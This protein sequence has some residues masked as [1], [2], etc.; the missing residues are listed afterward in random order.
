MSKSEG[1][2]T[3]TAEPNASV[4]TAVPVVPSKKK[5]TPKARKR[6]AS[7]A[8]AT[9]KTGASPAKKSASG[10]SGQSSDAAAGRAD[11]SGSSSGAIASG[12][13]GAHGLAGGGVHGIHGGAG[14]TL[15][16]PFVRGELVESS[17][18]CR[19]ERCLMGW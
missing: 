19:V 15:V 9:A 6:K 14:D 7:D 3:L 13:H 16:K 17:A 8:G 2:A 10:G 18:C 4:S 12:A 1:T 5:S 11:I